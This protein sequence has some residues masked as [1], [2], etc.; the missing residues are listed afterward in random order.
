LPPLEVLRALFGDTSVLRPDRTD[1][2]VTQEAAKL[3][4]RLAE[5]LEIEKRAHTESQEASKEQ[6][7]HFLMRILF[8][9]FADSVDLLPNR[10]FRR[11]VEIDRFYPR[12]FLLK[13]PNLFAAM[14]SADG[15]FGEHTIRYF[16]G[17][18]FDPKDISTILLDKQD[19]AILYDVAHNYNWAHVAPAIFGTLFE[20][21][22]DEARR[23]LIGAHYTSQS[24]ID[25]LV[26]PVVM[27]PL[28]Q[29]DPGYPQRRE[30]VGS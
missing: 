10:V 25:L 12:R 19:M 14:S 28:R 13:L 15:I 4:A 27:R 17:G 16:N 24:D 23:S 3:F 22:L 30:Q 21:S 7:A 5:R 2:Y 9:L 20:R 8:C 1:A 6:I 26:E 29:R 18:L 11:L